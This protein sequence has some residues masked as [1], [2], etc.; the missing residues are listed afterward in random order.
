MEI[1]IKLLDHRAKLPTRSKPDDAAYDLFALDSHDLMPGQR[2]LVKTGIAM[3]IPSGYYGRIAERSGLALKEGLSVGGGVCDASYSGDV[4]VIAINLNQGGA[5]DTIQIK[6]GSRIAQLV[7]ERCYDAD[8][9]VVSELPSSLR[10][11]DG[12]GSSGV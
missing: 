2:V 10:G 1:P 3:A 6:A 9:T 7:I 4:G 8:W 11:S 5:E 12:F